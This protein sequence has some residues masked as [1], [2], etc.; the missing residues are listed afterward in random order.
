VRLHCEREREREREESTKTHGRICTARRESQ[1][2]YARNWCAGCSY[3]EAADE[4]ACSQT[5]CRRCLGE[6]KYWRGGAYLYENSASPRHSELYNISSPVHVSRYTKRPVLHRP[7][8]AISPHPS[9]N[10]EKS[11]Q[12]RYQVSSSARW[13]Q[14]NETFSAA[15]LPSQIVG[16]EENA[17]ASRRS[18]TLIV[19]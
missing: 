12:R 11:P 18:S 5:A 15:E 10:L 13:Q 7:L 19:D 2:K 17:G 9:A 16:A 4:F 8:P 3:G 1:M 6:G 14:R